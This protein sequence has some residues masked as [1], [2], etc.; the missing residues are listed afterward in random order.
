MESCKLQ[1]LVTGRG[2]GMESERSGRHTLMAS[3]LVAT[4]FLWTLTAI[5]RYMDSYRRFRK[6]MRMLEASFGTMQYTIH[7]QQIIRACKSYYTCNHIIDTHYTCDHSG[8][9]TL[10]S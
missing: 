2:R 9:Q 1:G 3:T 6:D 4:L 7:T 5:T 10:Q 8:V